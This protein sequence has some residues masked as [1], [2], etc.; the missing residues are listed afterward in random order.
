MPKFAARSKKLKILDD[1]FV[2]VLSL[3]VPERED[4]RCDEIRLNAFTAGVHKCP[5][6][7]HSA[8]STTSSISKQQNFAS[9]NGQ[10]VSCATAK[11]LK[12]FGIRIGVETSGGQASKT[13]DL[14][15]S[16]LV[17]PTPES[18]AHTTCSTNCTPHRAQGHCCEI[19]R[20]CETLEEQRIKQGVT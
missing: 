6:T 7:K 19:T 13:S 11:L 9:W 17:K 10:N 12:C 4:E 20:S 5:V 2:E 8:T 16:E 14:S 15:N 18:Q 3:R 1:P